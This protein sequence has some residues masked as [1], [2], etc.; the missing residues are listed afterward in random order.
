LLENHDS[1]PLLEEP[2]STAW[3]NP[4][5]AHQ[6]NLVILGGGPGGVMAA[7]FAAIL[8]AKIALIERARLGGTCL[9]T[10]CI[11]SKA[12]LRTSR[13]Y[14]DM[15]NAEQFGAHVP[16]DIKVDFAAA[17]T[18]MRHIRARLRR[19]ASAERLHT[20]GIDVFFGAGR[21]TGPNSVEVDGQTLRFKKALIATGA[22]PVSPSILGLPEAGYLTHEDVF[23][24]TDCPPR[25][26]VIGGGPLGC[27]LAQ[28]FCR[29]GSKVIIVEKE[30]MFLSQEERDAAQILSGAL[31]R[32][33]IDI[34][35][36]TDVVKVRQQGNEK[37][38]DLV[39]DDYKSTVTVDQILVGIGRMPNVEHINLDVVG[40]E[41]NCDSGVRV[42]DFLQT[43]NSRIYA[44][45]DVCLE[46]KFM[47]IE[48][49]SARLVVRNALFWG[50][51]RL[52]ALTIP[53]CT[54]TDPEIAHVGLYVTEAIR[55]RVPVK[56]FTVPMHDVDRAIA[57]GE[58]EGF[59][60][61]HVK[62]G[63]DKIL[64]AT[65][66]ARHAGEIINHISVAID[67]GLGLNTLAR[68]IFPY[69]TQAAAIKMAADSY[70]STRL[71]ST[72]KWFL[73]HWLA[74]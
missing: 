41:Y 63:S 14:A 74:W 42:N 53:W 46:H 54:Y 71:T 51:E 34:R 47:H 64:G 67:S 60:K 9:N 33:G 15:R 22:H 69:P 45:G 5:P 52:S 27:E 50:R 12:I 48:D 19:R 38:V 16:K 43:T 21:F 32:D 18:R 59:V 25:L 26:L 65:V 37:L 1:S 49:A 66:V 17:M 40:V 58:Q 35:L 56:T 57:D 44:V 31:A 55:K 72:R 7:R 23:D 8:G 10:G 73:K 61:I 20:L 2:T 30:P 39:S 24:L 6:Y 36:N 4:R 28:A 13:L 11:P 29:L 3:R 62:E 68:I 70:R